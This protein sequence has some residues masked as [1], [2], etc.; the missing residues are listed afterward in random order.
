MN[1]L[2]ALVAQRTGLSQEN[3]QKAVETVIDILK[4]R[5]PAPLANHLDTFLAGDTS[6]TAGEFGAA[7]GEMLKGAIGSF[8]EKN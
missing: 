6:G 3:A 5:L 2:V 1:E 4:Q 8:F 7:A